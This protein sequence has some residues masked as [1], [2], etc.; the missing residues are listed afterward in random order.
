MTGAASI[1]VHAHLVPPSLLARLR[2]RPVAGVSLEDGHLVAGDRQLGPLAR[3][4]T[5]VDGRLEQLDR[6]GIALQWVSPWIDL[7]TWHDLPSPLAES[8]ALAVN[9]ALLEATAG[10]AG[11]LRSVPFVDLRRGSTAAI[12]SLAELLEAHDAPA[13]LVNASP[14]VPLASRELD[15]WWSGAAE[16]GAPILLHPPS[17]GPSCGFT[18]PV[19]QNVTGRVIDTSATVAELMVAGT[20][21]RARGVRVIVVHGGGFLPYQAFRL[22]GL[23]RAGLAS[24]TDMTRPVAETLRLMWY[25]TVALD[26]PSLE[27]LVRRVGAERVLLGSDAPFAI[28]DPHPRAT[29]LGSALSDAEKEAVCGLNAARLCAPPGGRAPASSG[30]DA[31]VSKARR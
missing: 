20:F 2:K 9:D 11:R 30:G 21:E 4:L 12:A 7:F 29:V 26:A 8:W 23:E 13:V 16:R 10:S 1:D 24:R 3:D 18:S 31:Q 14:G 6:E 19:L 27:L 25:D 17:N 15:D 5:D 22:E 28:G